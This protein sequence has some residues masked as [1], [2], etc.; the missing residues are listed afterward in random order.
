MKIDPMPTAP[1][2]PARRFIHTSYDPGEPSSANAA[3]PGQESPSA[4]PVFEGLSRQSIAR[5]LAAGTGDSGHGPRGSSSVPNGFTQEQIEPFRALER[6]YAALFRTSHVE[7]VQSADDVPDDRERRMDVDMDECAVINTTLDGF[8]SLGTLAVASCIAICAKGKN[9]RGHDILGLSHYSGV[10]DAHEVLSEIR[11][12]MQQKGARNPE[13]FLVGGLISNQEDLSSFE[14]ERDLL[15]LHNPFNIT[16]A[17]L[18]VSISDSDG[19]ANA[20][21][22]VMTKDKIYYHAAW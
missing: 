6:Q 18:H 19:E 10:A 15:A 1:S 13:M 7:E 20:V 3:D 14:M 22:V 4:T 11:E 2:I 16:G 21:D 9:R 12:G 5:R 17:K 8:D